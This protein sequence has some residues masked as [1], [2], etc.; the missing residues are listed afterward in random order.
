[1]RW[2][3]FLVGLSCLCAA[4]PAQSAIEAAVVVQTTPS[5][6][7]PAQTIT[8]PGRTL[9]DVRLQGA[10]PGRSYEVRALALD[11]NQRIV[12]EQRWRTAPQSPGEKRL[13]IF[14]PA[15]EFEPGTWRL[16]FEVGGER[17]AEHSI[18][19]KR[20]PA[21]TSSRALVASAISRNLEP[22]R[23][24]QVLG[25]PSAAYYYVD[26]VGLVPERE[27]KFRVTQA[28][29]AGKPVT[30]RTFYT[31]ASRTRS[32]YWFPVVPRAT[33][34]PG[35]WKLRLE[36]DDQPIAETIIPATQGASKAGT[37]G[38]ERW[39]PAMAAAIVLMLFYV[40]YNVATLSRAASKI[41]AV[42]PAS[43][44]DPVFAA[45]VVANLL[46]M[47]AVLYA[48]SDPGHVLLVYIGETFVIAA[49]AILRMVTAHDESAS[50][51]LAVAIFLLLFA[52]V[53]VFWGFGVFYFL[54]DATGLLE[55]S[56][57]KRRGLEAAVRAPSDVWNAIPL[58]VD[59]VYMIAVLFFSHSLSFVR[60][61]L[62]GGAYLV[63]KQ[64]VEAMRPIARLGL[65]YVAFFAMS[66][67]SAPAK[68]SALLMLAVLVVLKT[69]A[70]V[71]AHLRQ[72]QQAA[73]P[74]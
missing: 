14:Y 50:P 42:A 60:S 29:G 51:L 30:E 43:F 26:M 36:V 45:L 15:A 46:P 40:F 13:F 23:P 32:V 31:R 18:P 3:G 47:A 64:N 49:F 34:A 22:R 12:A 63:A 59:V 25:I 72:R 2:L 57:E 61:Y 6:D 66:V 24:L 7:S 58:S 17:I 35:S 16:V 41:P 73:S 48:G 70:D 56:P 4:S 74:H 9:V 5:P 19:A 1:M 54:D 33:D 44:L 21:P 20:L 71:H 69:I 67:F 55:L 27:Y 68:G 38:L 8:Y 37:A 11:A 39:W 53:T 65:I 28:D 62:K 52:T 10:E